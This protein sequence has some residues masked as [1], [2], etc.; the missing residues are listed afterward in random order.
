M[1][2]A[3]D[4]APKKLPPI[5]ERIKEARERASGKPHH[6]PEAVA[7]AKETLRKYRDE[8]GKKPDA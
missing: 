3:M 1:L 8:P 5:G 6:D 4:K 2:S 7:E